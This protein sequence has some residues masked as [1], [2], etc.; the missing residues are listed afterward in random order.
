MF[1]AISA[2]GNDYACPAFIV[3]FHVDKYLEISAGTTAGQLD[4]A[5]YVSHP[6]WGL[7]VRK[8]ALQRQMDGCKYRPM[9]VCTRAIATAAELP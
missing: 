3:C 7:G 4:L 5:I 6:S 9:H 8:G 1:D 2:P